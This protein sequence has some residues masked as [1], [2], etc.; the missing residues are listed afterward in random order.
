MLRGFDRYKEYHHLYN[1][2]RWRKLRMM[3]LL[4]DPICKD[5]GRAPSTVA[6]HVK[7]HRGNEKLFWDFNNLAGKCKP[8][9][10][11]K[12]GS[13]HGGGDRKPEEPKPL[14]NGIVANQGTSSQ[15]EE[16]ATLNDAIDYNA[17]MKRHQLNTES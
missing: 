9:H 16:P 7:D 11:K 13:M 5:C 17:L 14:E 6:D 10:D 4:R 8:C 12:T 15:T 1:N 3:V 2:S